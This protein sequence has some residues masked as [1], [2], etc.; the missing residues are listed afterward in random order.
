MHRYQSSI[1]QKITLGYFGTVALVVGLSLFTF[2]ELRFLEKKIMFGEII[3]EFFDT[4]L[5]IRRF[6]KNFFLYG[7][8]DDYLENARYAEKAQELLAKNLEGLKNISNPEQIDSLKSDLGR[9]QGLM[10]EYAAAVPDSGR[11]APGAGPSEYGMQKTILEGKIRETGKHII[12]VAEEISKT[13]RRNLQSI[14]SKS[15]RV[16]ILS[17]FSFSLLAIL[18]GQ[19]LSKLVVRPLKALEGSMREIAEG[20]FEKV[21]IDS[22]DREIVS[23]TTAFNKMLKEL[24]LRQRHLVQSEKLASLGTL[25]SGVAHELN[26]PLSNIYSSSQILT[27]EIEEADMAFKKELLAQIE[28]QT[29]RARNIVRSLLE[30]SREKEFRKEALPLRSVLEETIRFVKGQVPTKIEIRLEVPEHI[31]IF[32]DKQRIQQAFLNLI[33]NA[34]EAVSDEG[35]VVI[36]AKKHRAVEKTEETAEIYNYMKYR[37]KCT[38]E[39]DTVDIEIRDTGAGIPPEILHRVFDPFFTTKDVGK[40]SGLGLFIVHEIIEE[41]DGCIAVESEKGKGT[42]FFI[43]LPIK[44]E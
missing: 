1:R 44:S 5:E 43:S 40:G 31:S 14:L 22:H 4:T 12:T 33:K 13:E 42:V 36:R 26:N 29:D 2:L 19:A 16:L 3:S 7:K 35:E 11:S 27:E 9:Y 30:F 15:Q 25:L 32:A 28:E 18:I 20:R 8:R 37:G 24:E 23:L 6:E 34:I 41:H 21:S 17:I 10:K 38:I 39:G